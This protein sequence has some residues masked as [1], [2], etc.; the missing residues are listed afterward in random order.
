MTYLEMVNKV[1]RRL[2]EREVG[3][4]SQTSYSKLI[5]DFV[6]DAKAEVENA[7]KWSALRTTLT[8]TTQA[9]VFNYELNS[10]QNNFSIIDVI[11]DTSNRFMEYKTSVWFDNQFLNMSP[12]TGA[13]QFYSFNGVANDGDT[14]V[15]IYPIPDGVYQLRF[16]CVIRPVPLVLDADVIVIPHQP[17]FLL[18]VSKAI[19]E[20]GEDGG[21]TS[22]NA[23]QASRN[24]LADEIA[25]DAA[26]HPEETIW[27]TT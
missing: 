7:W 6:N 21:T 12:A 16:N 8:L 4:V 15:D 13:P 26:R 18:A 5:G 9:N 25:Y 20:R 3:A 14:Q 10:S 23:F 24:S 11:N 2:R 19:E 1:L 17:V 22:I 27:Y